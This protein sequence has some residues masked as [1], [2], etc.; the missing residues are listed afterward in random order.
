MGRKP[1]KKNSKHKNGGPSNDAA[2]LARRILQFLDAHYGEEF[3]SKQIVKKLEIRDSV[4]KGGVEPILH[5][6]AAG[7]SI[8]NHLGIIFHQTR[9]LNLLKV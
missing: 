6:L 5:K 7:G 3:N 8:S 2:N 9:N 4:V 1:E